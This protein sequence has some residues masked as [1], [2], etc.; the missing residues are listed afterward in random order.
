MTYGSNQWKLHFSPVI[1]TFM[2]YHPKL[3]NLIVQTNHDYVENVICV[4]DIPSHKEMGCMFYFCGHVF[5]SLDISLI[6]LH[7]HSW[8]DHRL[9]QNGWLCISMSP[10]IQTC[11]NPSHLVLKGHA[12]II[13][14]F[15]FKN[16]TNHE[17]NILA[18]LITGPGNR[19]SVLHFYYATPQ[20]NFTALWLVGVMIDMT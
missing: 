5:Q 11:P 10:P 8:S 16:C 6:R 19:V 4:L 15:C 7:M 18:W 20:C 13:M 9:A 17:K 1:I 12:N 2:I 3:I 14:L